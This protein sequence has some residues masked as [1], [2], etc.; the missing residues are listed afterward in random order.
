M[1]QQTVVYERPESQ[2]GRGKFTSS[3]WIVGGLAAFAVVFTA[4][5]VYV[6][7]RRRLRRN[8]DDVGPISSRGDGR[9][10]P[11]SSRPPRRP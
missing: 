6:L 2:L 7:V 11:P 4:A 5:F 8:R 3:P 9:A 1:T 10:G